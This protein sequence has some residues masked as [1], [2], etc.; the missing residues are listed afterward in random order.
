MGKKKKKKF[1][2]GEVP[3]G[4][5][6]ILFLCVWYLFGIFAFCFVNFVHT[7]IVSPTAYS[8]FMLPIAGAGLFI[9]GGFMLVLASDINKGIK[10]LKKGKKKKK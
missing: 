10:K 9:V 7:I 4:P 5:A 3:L 2:T 1:R 8:L 6:V